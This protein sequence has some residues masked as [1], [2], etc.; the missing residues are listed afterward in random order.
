M[1]LS[2][3]SMVV[4]NVEVLGPFRAQG[5]PCWPLGFP[6]LFAGPFVQVTFGIYQ[7]MKTTTTTKTLTTAE[8]ER[9]VISPSR[10]WVSVK[11]QVL[12][13]IFIF[14]KI[15]SNLKIVHLYFGSHKSNFYFLRKII[16]CMCELFN[17][18]N[19]M[20]Y[21]MLEFSRSVRCAFL[22]R[23]DNISVLH[24]W[25]VLSG[26]SM[27][28]WKNLQGTQIRGQQTVPLKGQIISIRGLQT[29]LSGSQLLTWKQLWT[30]WTWMSVDVFQ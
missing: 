22:S 12:G 6:S 26:F 1:P 29:L 27:L 7:R 8:S 25:R 11:W 2:W 17:Y 4:P 20:W 9:S 13:V 5:R 23:P 30:T 21:K 10:R 28:L 15:I 14:S 19:S 24:W 18:L 16:V 3:E